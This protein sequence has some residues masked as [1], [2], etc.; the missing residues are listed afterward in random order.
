MRRFV[1][2]A[3]EQRSSITRNRSRLTPFSQCPDDC[4][5]CRHRRL[6]DG[7]V[8][9]VVPPA[10]HVRVRRQ[11]PRHTRYVGD[12]D[13]RRRRNMRSRR[14]ARLRDWPAT[15]TCPFM[16]TGVLC[17]DS[18]DRVGRAALR[19]RGR[20]PGLVVSVLR[21]VARRCFSIDSYVDRRGPTTCRTRSW[22]AD[23]C[24]P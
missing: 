23:K 5:T 3:R 15:R 20:G 2:C 14:C 13:P 17:S 10:R 16:A 1:G 12:I 24:R 21:H 11:L 4:R 19:V 8:P 18:C 7:L 6:R 22:R 9:R